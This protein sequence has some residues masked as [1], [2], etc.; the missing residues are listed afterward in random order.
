M[1]ITRL[2]WRSFWGGLDVEAEFAKYP[3]YAGT[4]YVSLGDSA[5][6]GVGIGVRRA[7]IVLDRAVA[8]IADDASEM[9]FDFLNTTSG[10][11]DDTWTAGDY[12]TLEGFLL[13]WWGAVKGDVPPDTRL[14][15]ILWNRVGP[16]VPKPNPA[17]R[18]VDI[19]PI[20]GTGTRS[21]PP[22]CATAISLRH[23]IRPSWGRTYLPIA[24]PVVTTGRFSTTRT[25]ALVAAT[26]AMCNS[27]RGADFAPVVTS[28]R[29]SSA[30]LVE[31]VAMDDVI[32]I[33]RRRRWKHR[34]YLKATNLT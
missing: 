13:T 34:G 20:A 12:T 8:T 10:E 32:D 26:V 31:Y 18:I 9:H 4:D 14:S 21:L 5:A 1:S 7:T 24:G 19:T 2:R 16:G 11:P 29:L 23:G 25:D 27:A 3:S 28:E 17:E 22:Q 15:R 6:A 33:V 30:L